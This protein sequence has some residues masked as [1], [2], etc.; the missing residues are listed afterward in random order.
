V[1]ERTAPAPGQPPVDE[2]RTL[3]AR[4]VR[5]AFEGVVAL[6][7]FDLE[8]VEGE[9][10]GLIGPNGAGKTTAL[11]VLSGYQ[12]PSAGE[13]LLAEERVS[14]LAPHRLARRGVVR[15]FQGVRL[16]GRLTAWENV[17]VAAVSAGSSR[18]EAGQRTAGLLRRLR[19]EH[20]ADREAQGLPLGEERRLGICRALAT[21]GRFV[22]LDEPAAG[23][24][25]AESDELLTSL[26][27]VREATGV[28]LLVVE[29]D[30]R[31]IMRLCDRIHVLDSG[32]TLRVG[33]PDDVRSDP[34]VLAAYL[35]TERDADADR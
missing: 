13:V 21:G 4:G 5:V 35:G 12:R 27:E 24:N 17:Y 2:T 11:N 19:L 6:E 7:D 1:A 15:S 8:L 9:I 34:A 31:L 14:G 26:Q 23:L 16:F 32:R 28:G 20:R 18:R 29:H 30:M 25:E 10:Q 22:L 33:T 3:R